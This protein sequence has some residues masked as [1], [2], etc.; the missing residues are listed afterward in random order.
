MDWSQEEKV[1][2]NGKK[3][4]GFV[5]L[6]DSVVKPKRKPIPEFGIGADKKSHWLDF[7]EEVRET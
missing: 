2:R 5:S 1:S 3:N 6:K 4:D 7:L